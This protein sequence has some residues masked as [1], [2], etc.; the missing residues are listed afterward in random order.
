VQ[1]NH[2]PNLIPHVRRRSCLLRNV[3]KGPNRNQILYFEDPLVSLLPDEQRTVSL[4]GGMASLNAWT[5]IDE[6]S[7]QGWMPDVVKGNS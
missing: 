2:T 1:F 7:S 5:Y 3:C 4:L 6:E